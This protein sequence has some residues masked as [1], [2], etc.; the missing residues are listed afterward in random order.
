MKEKIK[1]ILITPKIKKVTVDAIK[2]AI[3]YEKLT[4]RKLGITGEIGEILTCN[5]LN[6]K[7]L[8]NPISEGYDAIDKN[9][10][11]YQIKTRR[12]NPNKGRLSRF[13]EHPFDYAILAILDDNYDITEL[14]QVPFRKLK[15]ALDRHPRRNPSVRE[16]KRLAEK[17]K[18]RPKLREYNAQ[19]LG[20]LERQ[21]NANF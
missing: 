20:V 21:V 4:G 16:F 9:N 12:G 13:S 11:K 17:I 8:T 19:K 14:W 2:I 6:L 1:T 15:P 5:K 18:F 3:N 7:L 10:K